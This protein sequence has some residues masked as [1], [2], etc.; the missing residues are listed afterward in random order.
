M[1]RFGLPEW[2][3][4]TLSTTNAIENLMGSFRRRPSKNVNRWKNAKMIER[5]MVTAGIDPRARFRKIRGYVGMKKLVA[6]V[7]AHAA[8]LNPNLDAAR[9]AA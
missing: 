7:H 8:S 2:L 6:A 3:E 9:K 1:K 5:W 4:R